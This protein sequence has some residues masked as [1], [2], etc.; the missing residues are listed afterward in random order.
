VDA[1]SY[2]MIKIYPN[3]AGNLLTIETND[4]VDQELVIE[5][6]NITGKVVYR[7]NYTSVNVNFSEQIDLSGYEMGV[8]LV[9]V[10]QDHKVRIEKLIVY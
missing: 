2:Q 5:I 10:R 8:Y 3:P 1:K 4:P 9:K 6:L 7:K